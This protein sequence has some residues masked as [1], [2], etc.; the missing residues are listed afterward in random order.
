MKYF[1][2][3][4]CL[5]FLFSCSI[6]TTT[7]ENEITKVAV[8]KKKYKNLSRFDKSI[9]D[10]VDTSVIYESFTEK[11]YYG[12]DD[13]ETVNIVDR[14]NFKDSYS[15]YSCY[16]FYENGRV[17]LFALNKNDS[18]LTKKTFDPN[19]RGSRGI[20]YKKNDNIFAEL[21]GRVTGP[22]RIGKNRVKLKFVGDTLFVYSKPY[23]HERIYL[24]REIPNEL[25]NHKAEW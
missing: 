7:L 25:L 4:I 16:K 13:S 14:L 10:I 17:N 19:F 8:N 20:Y 9:L 5:L 21:I 1:I 23:N 6:R 3:T 15:F 11:N 22:G 2:M 12:I 24:K 18:I